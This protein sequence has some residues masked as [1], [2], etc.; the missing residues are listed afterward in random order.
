MPLLPPE[1]AQP[2][3]TQQERAA[4]LQRLFERDRT[5]KTIEMLAPRPASDWT[6]S[7]RAAF[8]DTTNGV[9]DP[10]YQRVARWASLFA[11]ELAEVHQ[12]VQGPR[13]FSDIELQEALYLA[14]RLLAT[15]TGLPIKQVDSFRLP[16]SSR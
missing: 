13:P 9:S 16:P 6:T 7:E 15:V 14:G 5:L 12:L 1:L 10:P 11:E 2:I 3:R 4:T 8:P